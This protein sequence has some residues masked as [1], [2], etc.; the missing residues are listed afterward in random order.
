M[1]KLVIAAFLAFGP[2]SC[3]LYEDSWEAAFNGVLSDSW[4]SR[5]DLEKEAADALSPKLKDALQESMT[6]YGEDASVS[7]VTVSVDAGSTAPSLDLR[8]LTLTS[9]S[10]QYTTDFHWS[11]TSSWP[12]SGAKISLSAKVKISIF[13][14]NLTATIQNLSL[15]ASG[16]WQIR[17]PKGGG[18]DSATVTVNRVVFS[19]ELNYELSNDLV[20]YKGS[21]TEGT[22]EFGEVLLQE[23]ILDPI[24]EA[25]GW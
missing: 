22:A 20:R 21:W 6:R 1:R 7:E 10:T 16:T 15:S 25:Y 11:L 5:S 19:G 9:S 3:S 12:A 13:T 24:F 2:C 23:L 14:F 18:S 17:T 8:N 4:P